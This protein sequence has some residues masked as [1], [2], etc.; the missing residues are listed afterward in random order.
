MG[1][2]SNH[3]IFQ[4]GTLNHP[5]G[6]NYGKKLWDEENKAFSVVRIAVSFLFSRVIPG[7]RRS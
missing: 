5:Q 4:I 3:A 7:T 1:T 6:A 2:V